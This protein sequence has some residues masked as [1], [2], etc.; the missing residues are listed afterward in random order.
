[1]NDLNDREK[2][3]TAT[4]RSSHLIDRATSTLLIVDVQEKL[5]PSIQ[6]SDWLIWNIQRLIDGA[7]ILNV[8]TR[9]TEQY[10]KGLGHTVE[11]LRSKLNAIPDKS[12]FSCRECEDIIQAAIA[13]ERRQIVLTGIETH[14]CVLQ[15]AL[16]FIAAGLDVFLVVDA[17]GSRSH[18]DQRIAVQRMRDCGVNVVTTESVLF[19]W[20]E[21]SGTPEFKQISQLVK[22]TGPST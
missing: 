20:C 18:R 10:P 19:E 11:S 2:V 22:Q 9:A 1:M 8:P 4:K 5:I 3:E 15:T 14:V 21:V 16:D 13:E 12:L 17:V 7:D 6:H